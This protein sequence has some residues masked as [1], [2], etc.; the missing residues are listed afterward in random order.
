MT[1]GRFR[2]DEMYK[3]D[4]Q[5]VCEESTGAMGGSCWSMPNVAFAGRAADLVETM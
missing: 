3:G 4:A 1:A 2:K 5:P